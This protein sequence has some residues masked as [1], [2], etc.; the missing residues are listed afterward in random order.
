MCNFVS[1]Y[2]P[3]QLQCYSSFVGNDVWCDTI[4]DCY[5]SVWHISFGQIMACTDVVI[6]VSFYTYVL[7]LV[8]KFF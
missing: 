8:K 5:M 1:P 4:I 6:F 3:G 2:F 7:C